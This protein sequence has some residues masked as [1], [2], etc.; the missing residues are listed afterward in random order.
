MR[1]GGCEKSEGRL[2]KK[3]SATGW[4][5]SL[6]L[7]PG[8]GPNLNIR[9]SLRHVKSWSYVDHGGPFLGQAARDFV[10][11]QNLL[12]SSREPGSPFGRQMEELVW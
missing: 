1:I 4:Q 6:S 2:Q 9:L 10:V 8:A 3:P 11:E 5:E 7:G 12:K